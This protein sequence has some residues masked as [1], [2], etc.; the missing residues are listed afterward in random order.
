MMEE[1]IH[2]DR[3]H[4]SI[5]LWGLLNEGRDPRLFREL[6][7]TAKRMDPSRKTIYAE[8]SPERG[9]PLGTVSIPDVLGLNY[10]VEKLDE[11]RALLPGVKLLSSEHT[12][13]DFAR[14]GDLKDEIRQMDRVLNDLKEFEAREWVAGTALWSMHDYGTDYGVVWPMQKSGIW[15]A[16]R[17]P[18]AGVHALRARWRQEPFIKILGHWTHTGKDG[19]PIQ[20]TVVSSAEKVDLR[21][22][23]R[24][25]GQRSAEQGFA[26]TVP[27]EPGELKAVGRYRSLEVMDVKKTASSDQ[28]TWRVQLE[29]LD[30]ELPA[31]GVE[32]TLIT[33]S[34][35]DEEGELCPEFERPVS[36]SASLDGQPGGAE[37]LGVG[38]LRGLTV[39]AGQGRMVLRAGKRAGSLLVIGESPALQVGS[40]RIRLTAEERV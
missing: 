23:G 5:I 15:D 29:S 4:P 27:Y 30:Q 11:L 17:L 39:R 8:N 37:F 34:I 21:L 28:R 40:I 14:R 18:K 9:L 31:N 35:V 7:D 16:W 26:W 12:N 1:M 20:V 24:S 36:F 32:V 33:A 19:L 25:F 3:H 6:H 13:A 2:R 38:G 10:L 22:N